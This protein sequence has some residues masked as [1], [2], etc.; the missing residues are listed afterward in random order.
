MTDIQA[1]IGL[2][3]FKKLDYIISKRKELAERY[4]NLFENF[5]DITIPFVPEDY[6]H[7]YQSYMIKLNNS[8]IKKDELMQKLLEKGISTRRGIMT[9]HR[10]PYYVKNFGCTSLPVTEKISDSTM[11]IPLFVGMTEEEQDYVAKNIKNSL[12]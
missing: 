8:N 7:T 1:S 12:R 2:E 6:V 9:I 10:E 4:N 5:D 11:I 3:Q